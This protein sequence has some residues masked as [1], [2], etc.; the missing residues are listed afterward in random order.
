MKPH[1]LTQAMMPLL[2]ECDELL[3]I[4]DWIV[5]MGIMNLS[6]WLHCVGRDLAKEETFHEDPSMID[7]AMSF[8]GLEGIDLSEEPSEEN[9][10]ICKPSINVGSSYHFL[11][12]P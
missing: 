8:M 4:Y 3:R 1:H 7:V 12:I 5:M 9:I 6:R 11:Y 10:E 2:V